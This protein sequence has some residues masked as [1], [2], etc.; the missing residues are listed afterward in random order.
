MY[1][2][3]L[4]ICVFGQTES[5]QPRSV[6]LALDTIL[7]FNDKETDLQIIDNVEKFLGKIKNVLKEKSGRRS[8]DKDFKF[9]DYLINFFEMINRYDDDDLEDVVTVIDDEI[10]KYHYAGCKFFELL[11]NN[12]MRKFVGR[13]LNQIKDKTPDDLRYDIETVI[14]TL[15]TGEEGIKE[16]LDY[17]NSL[18]PKESRDKLKNFL[19]NIELYKSKS[20]RANLDLIKIIREGLRNAIFDHYTN[21]N[22]NAR[23]DFKI[24]L[25][26]FWKNFMDPFRQGHKV[27][28]IR[29]TEFD[30]RGRDKTTKG[31]SP[32]NHVFNEH[33]N[34]EDDGNNLQFNTVKYFENS[35]VT[36]PEVMEV[37][38]DSKDLLRVEFPKINI[39]DTSQKPT[40]NNEL[41]FNTIKDRD[42]QI[43]TLQRTS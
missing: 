6:N 40:N 25:E 1:F 21:L 32:V 12:D 23:K 36:T 13:K 18:Y 14:D 5:I 33:T 15:K 22:V 39:K 2:T 27:W 16:F 9:T 43:N 17:I 20:K 8:M 41:N 35:K 30:K 10:R 19:N 24:R 38:F 28:N 26:T 42:P 31:T 11:Q 4:L 7:E 29:Y 37:K 34:K 3:I